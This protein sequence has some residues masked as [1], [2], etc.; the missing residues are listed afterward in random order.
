M[1]HISEAPTRLKVSANSLASLDTNEIAKSNEELA[2][3][4]NVVEFTPEAPD[5]EVAEIFVEEATEALE[6]MNN[7]IK[8]LKLNFTDKEIL[9]AIHRIYHTLKGSGKIAGAIH[10]SDF[11]TTI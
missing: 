6:A 10:I 2:D 3:Q 4:D 1:T 7:Q 9:A 11:S 8:A 5:E